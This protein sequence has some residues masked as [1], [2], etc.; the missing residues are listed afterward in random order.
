VIFKTQKLPQS[1]P[2]HRVLYLDGQ[3]VCGVCKQNHDNEMSAARCL[4]VCADELVNGPLIEVI[5]GATQAKYRCVICRRK[6]GAVSAA[7]SCAVECRQQWEEGMQ[8]F[9][10]NDVEGQ[11]RK[12]KAYHSRGK[13]VPLKLA[14]PYRL[15]LAEIE[16]NK[17]SSQE[18]QNSDSDDAAEDKKTQENSAA[19]DV[20]N[21]E[22]GEEQGD[23]G[24]DS[25]SSDAK[26]S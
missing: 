1:L 24:V 9:S 23:A 17:S 5:S 19:E 2:F 3:F 21:V 7:E 15:Y 13:P 25:K 12:R 18:F 8:T 11:R 6:Y 26:K 22:D 10:L 16:E 4:S 20:S 14:P